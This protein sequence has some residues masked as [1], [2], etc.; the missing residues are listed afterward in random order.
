M[1][2]ELDDYECVQMTDR[3]SRLQAPQIWK[4]RFRMLPI[5]VGYVLLLAIIFL[6]LFLHF[7]KR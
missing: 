2:K 4:S 5:I 1:K 3:C 7:R 6:L